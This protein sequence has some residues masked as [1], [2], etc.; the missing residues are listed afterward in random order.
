VD[1]NQ[2]VLVGIMSA[3]IG[4]GRERLPGVYTRVEMFIRWITSQVERRSE[5]SVDWP[6][7][8]RRTDRSREEEEEKRRRRSS[9][10]SR[11]RRSGSNRRRWRS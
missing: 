11:D 9:S 6:V 8:D 7:R 1:S 4:C 10:S 3:G 5:R 2:L